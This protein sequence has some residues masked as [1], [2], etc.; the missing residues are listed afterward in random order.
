MQYE[1]LTAGSIR[2]SKDP[3]KRRP[4]K[5]T[6]LF[7]YTVNQNAASV[8]ANVTGLES[9]TIAGVKATDK[10][11]GIKPPALPANLGL[12]QPYVSADNTVIVPLINPTAGALD[13]AAGDWTFVIIASDE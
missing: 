8:A 2:I 1:E 9:F 3:L 10:V 11:I 7:Q 13:P 12:G 4:H 5:F 6:G